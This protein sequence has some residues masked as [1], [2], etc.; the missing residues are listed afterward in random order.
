MPATACRPTRPWLA[1]ARRS[2]A[3]S[4]SRP[5]TMC[6]TTT[7]RPSSYERPSMRC[8]HVGT[9]LPSPATT[10]WHGVMHDRLSP[11]ELRELPAAHGRSTDRRR[12][13]H[14]WLVG[15]DAHTGPVRRLAAAGVW[16]AVV[17]TYRADRSRPRGGGRGGGDDLREQCRRA[18]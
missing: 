5:P 12:A 9:S 8:G 1:S 2:P 17:S 10:V 4:V 14:R 6:S 16:A 13:G 15:L 7:A 3:G 11:P 18:G